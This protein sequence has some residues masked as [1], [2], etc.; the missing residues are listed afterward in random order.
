MMKLKVLYLK[1]GNNV[2]K[3]I[4]FLILT[5]LIISSCSE[6]NNKKEVEFVNKSCD[7][8]NFVNVRCTTYFD[9]EKV[10]TIENYENGIL[11]GKFIEYYEDGSLK[12]EGNYFKG[13][14]DGYFEYYRPN[15]Y[16]NKMEEYCYS[17]RE[18]KTILNAYANWDEVGNIIKEKSN[19]YLLDSKDSVLSGEYYS[20]EVILDVPYFKE[21][22]IRGYFNVFP[23]ESIHKM[24]FKKTKEGEYQPIINGETIFL[25]KT[26]GVSNKINFNS[27]KILSKGEYMLKGYFEEYIDTLINGSDKEKVKTYYISDSFVVI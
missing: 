3:F 25:I 18:N 19:Y 4:Y 26:E 14:K 12:I 13:E 21:S 24:E 8:I 5:L 7:T 6:V 27:D 9:T 20:L 2:N 23:I 1:K 17:Y 11:N 16:I 22:N 15:G 10:K